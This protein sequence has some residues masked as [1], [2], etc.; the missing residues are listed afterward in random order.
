MDDEGRIYGKG[1]RWL[2]PRPEPYGHED[3]KTMAT[4][5]FS[6]NLRRFQ[7]GLQ[8]GGEFKAYK[9]LSVTANVQWGLNGIFP[10]D[11]QSVTFDLFPIYGTIGF[12]YLF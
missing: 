12:N 10:S 3:R 2:H 9:H 1:F 5:D 7:W 4:Y 11:F 8:V 6:H